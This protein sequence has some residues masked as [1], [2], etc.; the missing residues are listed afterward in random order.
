M[1]NPI[2]RFVKS[3]TA[4]ELGFISAGLTVAIAAGVGTLFHVFGI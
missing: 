1:S 2:L 3:T 4:I